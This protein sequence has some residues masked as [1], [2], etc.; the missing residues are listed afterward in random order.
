MLMMMAHVCCFLWLMLPSKGPSVVGKCRLTVVVHRH[1]VRK[2]LVTSGE[3][4]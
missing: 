1:V 2:R 3:W 4:Q